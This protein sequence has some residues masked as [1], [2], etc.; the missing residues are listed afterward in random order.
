MIIFIL[1]AGYP[2]FDG[3]DDEE[4]LSKVRKRNF[5]FKNSVWNNVSKEAKDLI[6]ALL[7]PPPTRL[8]AQEALAHP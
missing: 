3:K 7:S 6:S 1:L 2:P 4:I 5:S 8:T